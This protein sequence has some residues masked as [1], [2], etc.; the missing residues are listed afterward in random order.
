MGYQ[1]ANKE[2][3]KKEKWMKKY[4]K[5]AI[6]IIYQKTSKKIGLFSKKKKNDRNN[7]K[8]KINSN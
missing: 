7:I 2:K 3:R 1:F 4:K 6:A 8:D 5:K